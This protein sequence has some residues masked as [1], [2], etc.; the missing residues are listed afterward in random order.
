MTDDISYDNDNIFAKIIRGDIP[1]N[2]VFEEEHVLAFY[3][4]APQAP[5]HV[6]VIP[7]GAYIDLED[8]SANASSEEIVA[9]HRAVAKII[10]DHDLKEG[11]RV[12]ANAGA[13]G[14]QEV[15]HYHLHIVGG[16]PIG[17]M[18]SKG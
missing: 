18:I 8:F 16:A 1:C 3:D 4:I 10:K 11:F 7:K 5:I 15:P 12:I 9:F 17:A 2:K 13:H 6:L 14:G